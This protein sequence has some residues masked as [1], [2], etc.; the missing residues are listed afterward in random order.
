[1]RPWRVCLVL[2]G[3]CACDRAPDP[4]ADPRPLAFVPPEER[5]LVI[6]PYGW[7][8]APPLDEPDWSREPDAALHPAPLR[9]GGYQYD[10]R[11]AD[12]GRRRGVVLAARVL[13]NDGFV[14]LFAC[15]LGGKEHESVLVVDADEQSIDLALMLCGLRRGPL[16]AS[17]ETPHSE[18]G[19]RVVAL[20]QWRTPAGQLRTFR[21]EDLLVDLARS[22][23]MPRM[24]WTYV[25][26]F[27][28]SPS[29]SETR[30]SVLAATRSRTLVATYNDR[31]AIL[32]NP[33]PEG[34]DD[35]SFRANRRL[36]PPAGTPVTLILRAPSA[37]EFAE[38]LATE[39]LLAQERR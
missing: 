14:E 26:A 4:T 6:D 29:E 28:E 32:D 37:P 5:T 19:H 12:G 34:A 13:V 36:L 7:M 18:Q 39:R 33:L 21:A 25:G 3:L 8:L 35:T 2:L 23:R 17:L 22:S 20:V 30:E 31:T 16:P 11:G 27:L 10:G 9:S 38:I 1:M 24:G 15:S